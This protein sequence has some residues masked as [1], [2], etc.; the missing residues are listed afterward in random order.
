V[1]FR[2][3]RH[4]VT[5]NARVLAAAGAL[6]SGNLSAFGQLMYESH[7]SL[8][9]DFE[10]SCPELDIMVDLAANIPGNYGSRM[11]GGGFGG[12]TI[13]LVAKEMAEKFAEQIANDYRSATQIRPTIYITDAANGA[14]PAVS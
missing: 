6:E 5:E 8:K 11:T 2:R 13:N 1:L 3:S 12:C 14:G 7:R 4:I 9:N 10:V